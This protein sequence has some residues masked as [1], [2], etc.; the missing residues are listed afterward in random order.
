MLGALAESLVLA[1]KS[2]LDQ[3]HVIQVLRHTTASCELLSSKGNGKRNNQSYRLSN[4]SNL[5]QE[6]IILYYLFSFRYA[7]GAF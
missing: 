5:R 7:F 2:G 3:E 1:D 4:F 6:L